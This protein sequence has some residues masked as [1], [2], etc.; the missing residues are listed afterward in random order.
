MLIKLE[1][2]LLN[3]CYYFIMRLRMQ[4]NKWF[5]ALIPVCN[6]DKS[7]AKRQ[8]IWLK[9]KVLIE[10]NRNQSLPLSSL[11]QAEQDLLDSYIEQRIKK[12][13]PLQYILGSQPFCELDIVTRPPILIPRFETEEWIMKVSNL[14]SDQL[15]K[16]Q[17][18]SQPLEI[19]DVGTGTGCI[20][21]ALA[22]HLPRDSAHVTG[23]DISSEAIALANQNYHNCKQSLN[24]TVSFK[25]IDVFK[26][27]Q[28]PNMIVSNP[29]YITTN[30]YKD[31][32]PDVKD[33][34]DPR[35]LVAAEEGT[36]VHK[37]IIELAKEC[38]PVFKD[39]PYLFME[40]GG[41]HQVEI[42]KTQ[43]SKNG[44]QNIEVW[45]DFADKDR[46]ILGY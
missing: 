7:H 44:F 11:S 28:Q 36:F 16:G 17:R 4:V 39:I 29:P 35:A 1:N 2:L 43:M 34:E 22:R 27:N 12:H 20:A 23:I 33:W 42:L 46:V 13:K 30:E 3:H 25:E 10:N 6:G 37:R 26:L 41:R 9:E 45:K 19:L 24:N 15:S 5:Q 31:L 8:L 38:R 21:L 14:I 18:L 40:I 32:E